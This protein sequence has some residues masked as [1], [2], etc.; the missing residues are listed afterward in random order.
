M[1]NGERDYF[2]HRLTEERAIAR[3]AADP[4]IAAIHDEL[5][6][7]YFVRSNLSDQ[8]LNSLEV[9]DRWILAAAADANNFRR[10]RQSSP[11]LPDR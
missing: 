6:D 1:S 11:A 5:A 10:T 4:T 8:E 7:H 9:E 2:R 3:T